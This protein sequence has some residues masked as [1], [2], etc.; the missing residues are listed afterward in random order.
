M[1]VRSWPLGCQPRPH[2]YTASRAVSCVADAGLRSTAT[3][4]WP[5]GTTDARH[6]LVG[7][8]VAVD[9]RVDVGCE[10]DPVLCE[11]DL[12][13]DLPLPVPQ[14]VSESAAVTATAAA[15]TRTA[16]CVVTMVDPPVGAR[17]A[18]RI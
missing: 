2:A 7:D 8:G 1:Y 5:L 6:D 17:P 13:L 14:A 18:G 3:I 11:P 10:V 16:R 9:V 15:T 4:R 12:C